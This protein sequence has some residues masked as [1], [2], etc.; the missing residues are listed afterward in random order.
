ML[1]Q[2]ESFQAWAGNRL[3]GLSK[4]HN[5]TIVP[6]ALDVPSVR[7]LILVR[8]LRFLAK[9]VRDG[10]GDSFHSSLSGRLFAS[11]AMKDAFN[12]SVVSQCLYLEE[13][14]ASGFGFTLRCLQQPSD[15]Y[16]L[17]RSCSDAIYD[18]SRS[19]SIQKAIDRPNL[20]YLIQVNER[21][22]WLKT[23][24]WALDHSVKGT[25]ACQ[26]ALNLLTRRT[27]KDQGCDICGAVLDDS[28]IFLEHALTDCPRFPEAPF[29]MTEL[30]D[31][32]GTE[33]LFMYSNI[34]AE[35]F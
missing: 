30:C 31:S 32:F 9:L 34:L 2:L 23:W 29:T 4:Y 26:L 19:L 8:K 17:A 16:H 14:F 24:D 11:L 3:L 33:N 13:S 25:K 10:T 12:I 1:N 18:R 35:H 15:A 28:A 22:S 7:S 20:K 6:I 5:N 27:Y 21:C